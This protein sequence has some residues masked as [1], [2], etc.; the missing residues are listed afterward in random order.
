MLLFITLTQ[1]VLLASL[2]FQVFSRNKCLLPSY[3]AV[4]TFFSLIGFGSI[5]KHL[6]TSRDSSANRP[7]IQ[8]LSAPSTAITPVSQGPHGT[9]L[10]RDESP[11]QPHS[12]ISAQLSSECQLR[13][14]PPAEELPSLSDAQQLRRSNL[15]G[16]HHSKDLDELKQEVAHIL[17]GHPEGVSLFQFRAEYSAAFQ[18]HLL[19]GNASSAKQC[20]LQMPDV[21]CLKGYGVQTLLFPV[22]SKESSLKTR[23]SHNVQCCIFS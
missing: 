21:V 20:L 11:S 15:T 16:P 9:I 18:K 3:S 6:P 5:S 1:F 17:A 10:V 7:W 12:G 13:R 4:N 22:S 2:K 23:K 19:L 8:S 14:T